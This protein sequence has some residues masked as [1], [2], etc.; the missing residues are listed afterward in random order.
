MSQ[1]S[2]QF[3]GRDVTL[4]C[5]VRH[6]RS[7]AATFLVDAAAAR[8]L[9]PGP[10]IE[11]AELLPGRAIATYHRGTVCGTLQWSGFGC[12]RPRY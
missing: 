5:V 2:Y 9:L 11:L 8:R 1:Q 4:P 6:A 7:G 12:H 10:E 3:Q